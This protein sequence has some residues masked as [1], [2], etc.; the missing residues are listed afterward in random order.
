MEFTDWVLK[1]KEDK[2]EVSD[3]HWAYFAGHCIFTNTEP[4]TIKFCINID[5]N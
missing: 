2:N 1:K 3:K 5:L 4:I